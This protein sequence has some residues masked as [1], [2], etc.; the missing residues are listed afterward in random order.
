MSTLTRI[1]C[2]Q[3]VVPS[4]TTVLVHSVLP[5]QPCCSWDDAPL[6]EQLRRVSQLHRWGWVIVSADCLCCCPQGPW[7][8]HYG[9][10]SLADSYS[11]PAVSRGCSCLVVSGSSEQPISYLPPLL[12]NIL[13]SSDF[14]CSSSS[15]GVRCSCCPLTICRPSCPPAAHVCLRAWCPALGC[16]AVSRLGK[17][18]AAV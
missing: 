6:L 12:T 17:G 11:W 2:Y 7:R 8:T 14:T 18:F 3:Q 9:S 16:P 1:I 10:L 4:K 5:I 13:L 15:S